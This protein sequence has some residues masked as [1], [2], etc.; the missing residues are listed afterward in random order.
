MPRHRSSALFKPTRNRGGFGTA[1]TAV[2]LASLRRFADGALALE[3][4]F[5]QDR[6]A[7]PPEGAHARR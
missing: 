6:Q 4:H 5:E 1:K 3:A 7:V 2:I